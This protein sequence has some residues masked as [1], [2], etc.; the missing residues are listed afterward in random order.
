MIRIVLIIL[1]SILALTLLGLV[2]Y[3]VMKVNKSSA[4]PLITAETTCVPHRIKSNVTTT[5][6]RFGFRT[7]DGKFYDL[8]NVTGL[9]LPKYLAGDGTKLTIR[10]KIVPDQSDNYYDLSGHIEGEVIS[11]QAPSGN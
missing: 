1:G 2:G 8:K 5:E 9:P 10:G 11:I 3:Y 4:I 7:A 6:C